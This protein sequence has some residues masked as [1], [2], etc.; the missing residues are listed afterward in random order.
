[1]PPYLRVH[2][3]RPRCNVW[4]GYVGTLFIPLLAACAGGSD[5]VAIDVDGAARNYYVH[6]PDGLSDSVPLLLMF[7]GGGPS[8]D[9]KGRGGAN[10]TG[11]NDIADA[12]GFVVAY[13]SSYD[14][15]WDDGRDTPHLPP[16]GIDDLAFVDAVIADIAGRADLDPARIY[17]TGASNGGFFTNRLACERSQTFAA[18]ANVIGSMPEGYDCAP[19]QPVPMLLMPGTEDPLVLWEGGAVAN[20]DR[21]ASIS[22][23]D[24]VMF[25]VDHNQCEPAPDT[26]ELPDVNQ[27]DNSVVR[28]DEYHSC[29]TGAEVE[30]WAVEGGGH[31]WPGGSQ[32]LPKSMIG[33]VNQDIDASAVIWEFFERFQR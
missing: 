12:E 17:A 2:R 32:Y 11:F 13:P 23:N 10:F 27:D 29:A 16:E 30:L 31:A 14:G 9:S 6:V 20:E 15:N 33:E 26:T 28:V 7:H 3:N 19:A 24:A 18:A 21:G 5:R 22:I 25:W 1:M 8:G 4:R